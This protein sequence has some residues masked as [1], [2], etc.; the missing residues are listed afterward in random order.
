MITHP[1]T[2]QRGKYDRYSWANIQKAGGSAGNTW[3]SRDRTSRSMR[4]LRSNSVLR[5]SAVTLVAN[6]LPR[7]PMRCADWSECL[8]CIH[9]FGK[10]VTFEVHN[11]SPLSGVGQ[12]DIMEKQTWQTFHAI[13]VRAIKSLLPRRSGRASSQTSSIFPQQTPFPPAMRRPGLWGEPKRRAVP[14]SSVRGRLEVRCSRARLGREP[15]VTKPRR[16]IR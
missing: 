3:W 6:W 1:T 12:P 7:P 2:I 9:P 15:S 16:N 11:E 5:C 4:A 13:R 8:D 14:I 10:S